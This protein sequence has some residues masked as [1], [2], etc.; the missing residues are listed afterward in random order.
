MY[1]R[2]VLKIKKNRGEFIKNYI[3]K[4]ASSLFVLMLFYVIGVIIGA[5]VTGFLDS[6]QND[7]ISKYINAEIGN[8]DKPEPFYTIL[9]RIFFNQIKPALLI[10]FCGLVVIGAPLIVLVFMSLGAITG[11]SAG[12]IFKIITDYR[13]ILIIC[14][15]VLPNIL[16]TLPILLVLGVFG[17]KMANSLRDKNEKRKN[18]KNHSFEKIS[19]S[20]LITL[21]IVMMLFVSSIIQATIFQIF[22]IYIK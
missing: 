20:C 9:T 7:V 18:I 6:S 16:F 14:Y 5:V 3:K 8:I 4:N 13:G 2:A 17:I 22:S 21:L 1:F 11:F 12:M 15:S 10:W 19:G